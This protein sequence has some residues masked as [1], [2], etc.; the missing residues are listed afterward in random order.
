[1]LLSVLMNYLKK[2]ISDVLYSKINLIWK[3]KSGLNVKVNSRA[4]WEIYNEIFVNGEYDL[5]IQLVLE[6]ANISIPLNI[7]DIG[8]N[9]GFFSVRFAD[10]LCQKFNPEAPFKITLIEGS[11]TVYKELKSRLSNEPYLNSR[12]NIIHGLAGE[13]QGSAKMLEYNYH[14]ANTIITDRNNGAKVEY[15]DVNSLYKDTEKIDLMKCDIEGA[16]LK[17]IENHQNLLSKVNVAVFELH[18]NKCDTNRCRQILKEVGLE[19][20][21][22]LGGTP[23]FSVEV[24]W[25]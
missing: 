17:F 13:L 1:M 23:P 6:K 7:L 19:N 3:L 4:D 20:S 16:E 14:A 15:I 5:P 10:L 22:K 24:F 11:P 25:R 9:V 18:D 12:T 8:A 21:K 2:K